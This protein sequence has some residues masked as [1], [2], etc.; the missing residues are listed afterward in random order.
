MIEFDALTGHEGRIESSIVPR[1]ADHRMTDLTAITGGVLWLALVGGWALDA[2]P[3]FLVEL[4]LAL[5]M[6]VLVPLGL[7]LARTPRRSGGTATSYRIAVLAQ[8]PC[9]LLALGGF[10]YSVETLERLL[11][12]LPWT[13]LT[14]LVG[15]FGAWRFLSTGVDSLPELSIDAALL[16]MPV[17]GVALV[18]HAAGITF[19]FEDI[20]VLLTGIHFHY[21]GFVLPLVV[22]LA[23]RRLTD[24]AGRFGE[25]TVGRLGAGGT[26]GVIVGISLIAFAIT[27]WSLL[28]LPA[29]LV[30]TCSVIAIAIA[31]LVRLVPTLPF[32]PA[33][34]LA[35][36]SLS[37][38]LTLVLALAYSYSV[39]PGTDDLIG[40][41]A[42]IRWHGTINALGFSLSGLLAFR[43]LEA[44]ST[45]PN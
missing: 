37:I 31:I 41:D 1:I 15:C 9:A 28:E 30:F 19:H 23:G 21:A 14:M 29:V 22:G 12:L 5:A 25:D 32:G 40:I 36:A 7:G 43:W 35:I 44:E 20:I 24:E 27:T 26:V 3:Y 38:V 39:F 45:M 17:A 33:L 13:A 18:L 6:L 34:L 42:M 16:Y 11:L 10:T 4:Y 2:V 8:F